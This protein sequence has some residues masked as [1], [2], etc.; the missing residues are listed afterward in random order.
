MTTIAFKD[1]LM[2]GDSCWNV[3]GIIDTLSHKIIR[4]KSGALLGQSG[5]NDIRELVDMLQN[6]KSAKSLPS[7]SAIAAV[8]VD[9]TLL[10]A[11]QNGYTFKVSTSKKLTHEDTDDLGIWRIERQFCA[12]GAGAELA[13]GAMAFGANA[14]QAVQIACRWDINSRP[15]VYS[16]PLKIP[17]KV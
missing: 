11:L 13:L 16:Y 9:A 17:R 2:A 8:R 5:D 12:I 1:G 3:S 10:L 6:V 4:L 15:P 14:H 7:Y